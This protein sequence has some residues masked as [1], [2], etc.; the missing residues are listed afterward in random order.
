[1]PYTTQLDNE[2][3]FVGG[4][5]KS[6]FY[7]GIFA[8]AFITHIKKSNIDQDAGALGAAAIAAVGCDLWPSFGKIDEIHETVE[9]VEPRPENVSKY[10]KLLTVFALATDYQA[11]ISDALR[12]VEI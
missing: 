10:E 6:R 5:A 11:K 8:D 7:L 3:L 9:V 4:G 1:V 12:L 2:I